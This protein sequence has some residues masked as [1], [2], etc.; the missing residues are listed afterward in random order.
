MGKLI[1]F[2]I[3]KKLVKPVPAVTEPDEPWTAIPA[4]DIL[5]QALANA[6]SITDVLLMARDKSG[7]LGFLTNVEGMAE[8]LLFIE[9]V[10]HRMMTKDADDT[11]STAPK[12]T[13]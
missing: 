11:P 4:K 13:A 12:G 7:E 6:G 3:P 1:E 2:Y 9:R 8:S 10:R 5:E